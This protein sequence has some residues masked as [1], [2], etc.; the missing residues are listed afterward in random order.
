MTFAPSSIVARVAII[1]ATLGGL[2]VSTQF[3]AQADGNRPH[4]FGQRDE[5][6]LIPTPKC[7]KCLP[8]SVACGP[9]KGVFAPTC[10]YGDGGW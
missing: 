1:A 10:V 5:T 9:E 8:A 6:I 2:V 4:I 7:S 3:P